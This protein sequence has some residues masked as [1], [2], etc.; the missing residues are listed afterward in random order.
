MMVRF[1]SDSAVEGK[2]FRARYRTTESKCGGLMTGVEGVITSPNYPHNY[3][4]DDDCGWL[5]T[6]DRDHVVQFTFEDFDVEPH[7]NCSY[8]HVALYDG[9][10]TSAPLLLMHCGRDLPSPAMIKSSSNQMFIRLRRTARWPARGSR[11]TTPAGVGR[12]S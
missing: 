4:S 7:S 1:K 10:S 2:G 6:V 11:P 8:D 3:D 9:N 12:P 5:V